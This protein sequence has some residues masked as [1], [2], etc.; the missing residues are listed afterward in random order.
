M[1]D[2][3]RGT[4]FQGPG[5]ETLIVPMVS[6]VTCRRLARSGRVT[7]R[8]GK[9]SIRW[10]RA[11]WPG[12]IPRSSGSSGAQRRRTLTV[13]WLVVPGTAA[14]GNDAAAAASGVGGRGV[15]N[16]QRWGKGGGLGTVPGMETSR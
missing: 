16:L 11:Q 12:V 9:F 2:G 4:E 6:G 13:S 3:F 15:W 8:L 14:G 5:Q 1:S 7:G 10:Q